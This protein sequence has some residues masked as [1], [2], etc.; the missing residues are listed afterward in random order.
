MEILTIV[1]L[2]GGVDSVGTLYKLLT[3][4][5]DLIVAHHIDFINREGRY[6][7]ERQ[8][9]PSI[10]GYLQQKVRDFEYT[11][12][13]F[14]IPYPY[15]GWDIINAMYI[16][17]IVAKNYVKD[18][19]IVRLCIG[20]N[21]DDF[22][23]RQYNGKSLVAQMM[24]L[25]SGL[26]DPRVEVQ[27]PPVIINPVVNMTKKE[28]IEMLPPELYDMTWSC[29][30]PTFSTDRTQASTCGECITCADLKELG[31][32]RPKTI[33]VEERIKFK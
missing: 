19:R 21:K 7:V 11:A 20:D 3:Q 5:E 6:N 18:G 16:G 23:P 28:I 27:T 17:G 15:F 29:R 26:D 22:A 1:M 32:Y 10:V 31:I 33:Q 12:S 4:T 30:T 13:A 24:G 14:A 25:I 2:S 8:V 9:V